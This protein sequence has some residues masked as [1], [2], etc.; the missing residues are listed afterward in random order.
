LANRSG[1]V[2]KNLMFHPLT[3]VA[4][5]FDEPMLRVYK[6]LDFVPDVM[7][8]S[9]EE[10]RAICAGLWPV[11]EEVRDGMARKVEEHADI[12]AAAQRL[13]FAVG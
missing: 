10:R 3:G 12:A 4:G 9:G 11:T 2:G 1:L 7:G 5:V 13:E 6:H 8:K